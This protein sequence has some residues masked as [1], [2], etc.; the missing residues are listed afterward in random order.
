MAGKH[1]KSKLDRAKEDPLLALLETVREQTEESLGANTGR[2][3]FKGISQSLPSKVPCKTGKSRHR[4][5]PAKAAANMRKAGNHSRK[6]NEEKTIPPRDCLK[7]PTDILENPAPKQQGRRI[8]S[9]H[10]IE[11]I[12]RS[13]KTRTKAI[14]DNVD[15]VKDV[16]CSLIRPKR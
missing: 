2:G 15:F 16:L 10:E 8:N 9:A 6:G 11:E 14:R 12:V 3:D 7:D 1:Q 5:V 13:I 4:K